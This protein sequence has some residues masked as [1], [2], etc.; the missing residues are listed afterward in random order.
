MSQFEPTLRSSIFSGLSFQQIKLISMPKEYQ[1]EKS[2]IFDS[3]KSTK[4]T[5]KLLKMSHIK[6]YKVD[7]TFCNTLYNPNQNFMFI[8]YIINDS[9]SCQL[10]NCL[11]VHIIIELACG[12]KIKQHPD[13]TGLRSWTCDS[14]QHQTSP[15]VIIPDT[16]IIYLQLQKEINNFYC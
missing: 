14:D 1:S 11:N 2:P 5:R 8:C 13:M 15:M 12:W 16:I 10:L 9:L 3:Q 6:A 4:T 7:Q